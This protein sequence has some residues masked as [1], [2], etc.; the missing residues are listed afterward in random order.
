[1]N[2]YV[3]VFLNILYPRHC[4]V[5]HRI[6]KDQ[7]EY[8]GECSALCRSFDQGKS[9]F[10][11]NGKLRQSLVRYKYY[12]CRE[13]GDYYADAVCRYTGKDI[14]RW[15]PDVIVPVPLTN[16]KQ[17]M[18][19]FNQSA[20]LADRVGEQLQIPVAY[21]LVKKV[22]STKSQ[23]KLNA[24]QRRQN[25]ADA[26]RAEE[27]IRGLTVLVIDDVYTTGSTVDAMARCLKEAGAEHVYFITLCTGQQ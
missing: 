12:G 3:N 8:C 20:Y 23:K 14:R 13:Y 10:I 1:M 6:L 19:G 24:A 27:N 5:C 7:E 22:R 9:V 25:L 18:R 21:G 11:Y 26:F 2:K 17:R 16:R 4:P 15:Q